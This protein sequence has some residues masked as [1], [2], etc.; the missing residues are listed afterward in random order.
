[1][2]AL[3]E[4]PACVRTVRPSLPHSPCLQ[5]EEAPEMDRGF[6]DLDSALLCQGAGSAVVLTR[7]WDR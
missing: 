5:L 4:R 6:G 2:F 7:L 1:M 3:G